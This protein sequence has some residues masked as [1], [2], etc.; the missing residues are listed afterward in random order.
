MSM[1]LTFRRI[2][3]QREM[4]EKSKRS[5][6]GKDRLGEI[7]P[8]ELSTLS[9][10]VNMRFRPDVSIESFI[11]E[12]DEI[13]VQVAKEPISTKG[14][15]VTRHITFAGRHIVFMPFIEHTECLKKNRKRKRA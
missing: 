13:L 9:E 2:E 8:D 11:K 6:E 4:A 14:P 5:L 3:E 10:A 1:T 12:G 7:I 15:R